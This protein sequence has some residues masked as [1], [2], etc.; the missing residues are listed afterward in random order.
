MSQI[1][2]QG[3]IPLTGTVK[4]SGAKNSALKLIHTAMFS[5]EDVI[6]ENIP[7]IKNLEVDL[8]IIK[9]VGGSF[10]WI[11]QNKL[12]LN[13]STINSFEIPYELGSKYR[14]SALLAAPLV[15]RFG[16]AV[17]PLP[18]GCKIGFRPINR[19]IE[20]WRTLG[21]DVKEDDKFV[22]IDGG[23]TKGGNINFKINSHMGTENA[24]M[25]ALFAEGETTINNAAEETEIEDMIDLVKLMGAYV[26]RVEH[27]TIKVTGRCIFKGAK[28]AVQPDKI[29]AVTFAIAAL[30]TGGNIRIEGVEQAHILAFINVLSKMGARFEFDRNNLK[31]WYSGEQFV[32]TNIATAP[33]PGFMTDWQPLITL[34]LTQAHGTSFVHD[35]IYTDRFGY[36]QDLNR[37][38][39][40][41]ELLRPSEAGIE[42]AI[43]DDL[44]DVR[45][46]GEPKTVAK[47]TG[48]TMLKGG[49]LVIPDLRAGAALVI[50][51]LA[52]EGKSE[53]VGYE[54]V[55]R[56]YEN[57]A[58]KLANLGA[59]ID[60]I[61]D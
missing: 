8:E 57:F 23:H 53:L 19:W 51:A 48:P 18:G 33:A 15:Y 61:L 17:I 30:V 22:Y 4:T 1:N 38:G 40:N 47:I 29:E 32:P 59:Q 5:N 2:I 24:I 36:A 56:G 34:L 45:E 13:G 16:K 28:F 31:V 60:D 52:A 44:Y 43:S 55:V 21:M 25:S 14:T 10:E 7:R 58:T 12:R 49:K 26:E 50:A 42:M 46:Q 27:R 54:H 35:T 6:L 9:A 3:G 39:A 11:G 37:M 41:I 20:T